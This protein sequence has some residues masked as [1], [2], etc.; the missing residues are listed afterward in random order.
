MTDSN[1]TETICRLPREIQADRNLSP[2]AFITQSGYLGSEGNITAE[3][4]FKALRKDAGLVE[5]WLR[6]SEDKRTPTGWYFKKS[7]ECY[8]VDEVHRFSRLTFADP[9]QACAEFIL[10]E[11]GD[12][13]ETARKI[14]T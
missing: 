10:R 8:V 6:W 4:L 12:I 13:A 2:A 1:L 11:I 5:D 7:G 3:C 14:L 9:V